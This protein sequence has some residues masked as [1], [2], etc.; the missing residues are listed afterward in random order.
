MEYDTNNVERYDFLQL[1][2]RLFR[3]ANKTAIR[4]MNQRVPW[5]PIFI[6][7]HL[8]D[9]AGSAGCSLLLGKFLA[10]K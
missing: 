2:V 9:D 1:F 5:T 10:R 6:V 7:V 8:V 4:A 3:V